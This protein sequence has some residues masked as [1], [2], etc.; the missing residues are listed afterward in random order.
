[1]AASPFDG[2]S[3][4]ELLKALTPPLL[5]DSSEL[6]PP[7]NYKQL[8]QDLFDEVGAQY[9]QA[10]AS[11]LT[12]ADGKRLMYMNFKSHNILVDEKAVEMFR[13]VELTGA[14]TVCLSEA[15]VP[16]DIAERHGEL[17]ELR[18][19]A[20]SHIVQPYDGEKQNIFANF[21]G[22]KEGDYADAGGKKASEFAWE[23]SFY[24]LGYRFMIFGNPATCPWGANWGNLMVMKSRP[25]RFEVAELPPASG[26]RGFG[27]AY[28]ESRCAI[29]AEIDGA[30]VFTTH[31]E[32]ASKE[33]R[34]AQAR[35]VGAFMASFAGDGGSRTLVGDINSLHTAS[36]SASQLQTMAGAWYPPISGVD[37]LPRE[38]C[39]ILS[40][41]CGGPPINAGQTYESLY[42]KCV[43]HGWSSHFDSAFVYFTPVTD[44]DHQP[45]I[46][47]T[48]GESSGSGS[49]KRAAEEAI[50]EGNSCSTS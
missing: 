44:F 41:A 7:Y 9:Q 28:D 37:E 11:A 48:L 13:I 16:S 47:A 46:L 49:R 21:K 14:D 5:D 17:I 15:L 31:L 27:G 43:S 40:A 39:D 6:K 32:N 50:D 34:C 30:F 24:Q 12:A 42:Q 36:Y 19:D 10:V 20:A 18:G 8:C 1:M 35:A 23:A 26:K 45:L 4:N 38:A 3:A 25:S 22:K 33:A 2:L 29:G